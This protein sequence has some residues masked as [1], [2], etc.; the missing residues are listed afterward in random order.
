MGI[1]INKGFEFCKRIELP[2]TNATVTK[3]TWIRWTSGYIAAASVGSNNVDTTLANFAG[4]ADETQAN[5]GSAGAVDV[6]VWLV[7]IGDPRVEIEATPTGTLTQAQCGTICDLE[8]ASAI[9]EDD[10]TLAQ[11]YTVGFKIIRVDTT[12]NLA[13]GHPACAGNTNGAV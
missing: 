13:Y 4:I 3:E 10:T 2:Q 8:S 11:I 7:P 5:A 12:N 9:D 1:R 6:A